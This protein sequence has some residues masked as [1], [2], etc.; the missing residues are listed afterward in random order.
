VQSAGY[1]LR[2]PAAFTS[3]H[4]QTPLAFGVGFGARLDFRRG[5]RVASLSP[6]PCIPP[7]LAEDLVSRVRLGGCCAAGSGRP[8]LRLIGVRVHAEGGAGEAGSLV[9]EDLGRG[10]GAG[11]EEGSAGEVLRRGGYDGR[12]SAEVPVAGLERRG[13]SGSRA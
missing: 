5:S 11:G 4:D 7:R 1:F 10:A 8:R 12:G 9:G 6:R 2:T 13:R 3:T